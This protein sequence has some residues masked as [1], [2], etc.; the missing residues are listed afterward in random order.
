MDAICE[1]AERRGVVVV[2]DAAQ[3]HGATWRGRA[4]GT[5]GA[6]GCFSFYP[7]KN[8]GAYGDA[9]ACT[10]ADPALAARLRRLRNYGERDRYLSVEFG[11]N[12]RLDELQAAVLRVKLPR[13]A[14]WNARRRELAAV[15]RERLA[16]L[17]VALSRPPDQGEEVVHLFVAR[18]ARRDRLRRALHDRGVMTQVHYPLPIHL[19]PAYAH[20]GFGPGSFPVA[21]Q[22]AEQIVSLP[23]YPEL[24]THQQERV[25]TA[26]EEALRGEE[27]PAQTRP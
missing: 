18:V 5:M 3:A 2:E 8:L 9:G 13:L 27:P 1:L 16:A 25:I 23:L 19:H 24:A 17:P 21:E 6:I 15:Y 11:I 14:G 4:A 7:S 20:L 22:R 12:S 10:T 26:V